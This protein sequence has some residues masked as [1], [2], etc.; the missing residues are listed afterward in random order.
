MI[1]VCAKRYHY[2]IFSIQNTTNPFEVNIL[3]MRIVIFVTTDMVLLLRSESNN[4]FIVLSKI[5]EWR[6]DNFR[7]LDPAVT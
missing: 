6:M 3:I 5:S 7:E 1:L 4:P 2:T